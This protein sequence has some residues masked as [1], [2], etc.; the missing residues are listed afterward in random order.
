MKVTINRNSWHYR[1]YKYLVE[2][3]MTGYFE[4]PKAI[5]NYFWG[6]LFAN[7]VCLLFGFFMT[8][9]IGGLISVVISP[10]LLFFMENFD[11]DTQ[12]L[13]LLQTALFVIGLGYYLHKKYSAYRIRKSYE[14]RDTKENGVM[15]GMFYAVKNKVC[16]MIEYKGE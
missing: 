8:M 1:W 10:I 13:I 7:L 3:V 14:N 5:C 9:V 16:P 11:E 4:E 12:S 15:K 6:F 2:N